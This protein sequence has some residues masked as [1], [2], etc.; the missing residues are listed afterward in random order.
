M[1]CFWINVN[2][3][4]INYT[5]GVKKIIESTDN[6]SKTVIL[7]LQRGDYVMPNT[8]NLQYEY[9]NFILK[10]HVST[11]SNIYIYI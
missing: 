9:K 8:N 5:L 2:I 3:Y 4:V 7:I 1:Q 11:L 10:N 6:V